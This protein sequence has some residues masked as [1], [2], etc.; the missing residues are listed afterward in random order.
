MIRKLKNCSV[1]LLLFALACQAS[2]ELRGA[3][4]DIDLTTGQVDALIADSSRAEGAQVGYID[5]SCDICDCG[6]GVDCGCSVGKKKAAK[7]PC[8]SSHKGVYYANDFSY[9]N[10]PNYRGDCLGDAMKLMPV[11][12][13]DWG[14]LD[15]G[16]QLRL[17]YNSEVGMGREGAASTARFQDTNNDFLLTRL[18]LYTNWKI[19]DMV[20]VYAEGIFADVTDDGGDYFPRGIDENRGDFLNLFVD[21]RLTDNATLRIGRQ[22]LLYGNQRLVSPLDWS[23]TRRTFEG[24]RLL[25][26]NGDW[27]VDTFLTSL[28]PVVAN[29]L[30]EADYDQTFYGIY[31]TYDGFENVS[32]ESYYLGYD[33]QNPAGAAGSGDFSLHTLGMRLNGAVDDWLWEMEGGPQFGRQS[34]SGV[35]HSAAFATAGIGRKMANQPGTPTLWFYYDYA[36]GNVPGGNFNGFNQLFPLSHKYFGFIDAVQRSNVEAPNILLKAQPSEKLSLLLW[37]WHFMS[38]TDAP[39]PSNGNTPAQTSSRNLGDELDV[40]LKRTIGPRSNVLLGWSHFWRGNKIIGTTDADFVY[41]QW[42]LNF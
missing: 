34:G 15:I 5:S 22:E 24:G 14:T 19:N 32:I 18:R 38:N 3:E 42:E 8:A 37:Y 2:A 21:L 30:D 10:D 31:S 26:K 27:T 12:G 28:V 7:N 4:G 11:A 36:S 16:G 29:R 1:A 13:G 35:G 25:Y 33:N 9:L 39:V 41:G 17:R 23:N 6:E 20:R 40:I